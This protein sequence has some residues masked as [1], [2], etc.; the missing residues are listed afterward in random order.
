MCKKTLLYY[1]II[2]FKKIF[3]KVCWFYVRY[4]KTLSVTPVLWWDSLRLPGG[5]P[6]LPGA[7]LRMPGASPRLPGQSPHSVCP[8]Q[9]CT[10]VLRGDF[11]RFIWI[12]CKHQLV[13][14]KEFK[15]WTSDPPALSL[16]VSLV[17]S[18]TQA[19]GS[20]AG[21]WGLG[22]NRARHQC[23]VWDQNNYIFVRGL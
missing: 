13:A 16:G 20:T 21:R 2:C 23:L 10:A 1:S 12:S 7:S 17:A 6:R 5:T 15:R 4:F 9:F 18:L 22:R 3:C 8:W 14:K 19:W 11:K